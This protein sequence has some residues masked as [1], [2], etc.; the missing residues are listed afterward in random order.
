MMDMLIQPGIFLPSYMGIVMKHYK[1]PGINQPVFHLM[2]FE[3]CSF[4]F[5]V[6]DVNSNLLMGILLG[7]LRIS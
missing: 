4:T 1:D 2:G 5:Q 6:V 7:L 3:R